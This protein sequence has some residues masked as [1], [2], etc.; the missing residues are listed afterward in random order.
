VNSNNTVAKLADLGSASM[1]SENEITPYLVT[2][3]YRPPEIS[4]HFLFFFFFLFL[5]DFF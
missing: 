3:F 2:R 4:E 1:T 5:S